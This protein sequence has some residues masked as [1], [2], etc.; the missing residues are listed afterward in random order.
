MLPN[1]IIIYQSDRLEK[2]TEE[3]L[4]LGNE[5]PYR[6]KVTH[7]INSD[8]DG[9]CDNAESYVSGENKK[10]LINKNTK[11]K[12]YKGDGSTFNDYGRIKQIFN[13]S[14]LP[15]LT[16]K[17]G[18]S[19]QIDRKGPDPDR[20]D[21]YTMYTALE[22]KDGVAK[23]EAQIKKEKDQKAAAKQAAWNK[24]IANFKKKYGFD[25]SV[26]DVRYIVKV[27]RNLLGILD[28]R[29][30][31][32][33][34]YADNRNNKVTVKL[35]RDQGASKCYEFYWFNSA[36]FCGYFWVRNNIITSIRWR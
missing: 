14:I 30:E 27:G 7:N 25:P 24:N 23:T 1:G 34:E 21:A 13:D 10:V 15:Y 11:L 8:Y 6:L 19:V 33:D 29:N 4:K 12:I 32:V 26:N 16:I 18:C 2:E 3:I 9:I 28:A 20:K 31:W 5:A 36:Y 22:Y 17:D 35:V